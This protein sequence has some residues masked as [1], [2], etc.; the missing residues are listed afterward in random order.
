VEKGARQK[1]G[2]EGD[3]REGDRSEGDR[4]EGDRGSEIDKRERNSAQSVQ[5]RM[6]EGR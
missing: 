2:S 4:R 3:R 1:G 5:E 6:K